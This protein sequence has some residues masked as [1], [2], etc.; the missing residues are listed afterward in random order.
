MK[1]L[2]VLAGLFAVLATGCSQQQGAAAAPVCAQ[3]TRQFE[4]LAM[5]DASLYVGGIGDDSAPRESNRQ[6]QTLN[7]NVTRSM[8]VDIA[9]ANDCPLT[10]LPP[11][12]FRYWSPA[13]RCRTAEISEA[14]DREA[15]C[16][17]RNWEPEELNTEQGAN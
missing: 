7:N 15:L 6:L 12:L 9:L 3:I 16:D 5:S 2:A 13:M 4:G 17:M 14:N 11:N 1:R 8:L 10:E